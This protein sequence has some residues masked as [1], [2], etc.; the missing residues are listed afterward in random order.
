MFNIVLLSNV[1][2]CL[3][4]RSV[5]YYILPWAVMK[6]E[7]LL[8]GVN[9]FRDIALQQLWICQGKIIILKYWRKT[10]G[11]PGFGRFHETVLTEIFHPYRKGKERK[12]WQ[13]IPE[14]IIFYS[15]VW[16][17]FTFHEP[18]SAWPTIE[19]NV[20]LPLSALPT[21][22]NNVVIPV[23][24][25]P[26]NGNNVVLPVSA[27]PTNQ[28]NIVIPVSALPTNYINVVIPVSA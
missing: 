10:V 14:P 20:V 16:L 12:I 11:F 3:S 8:D 18:V 13:Q 25:L 1:E 24:A 21:H 17:H 2:H 27:L 4:W 7:V 22:G 23:S 6:L 15:C 19:N 26:T 9:S 5:I 28:N